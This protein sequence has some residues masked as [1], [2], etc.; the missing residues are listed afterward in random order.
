M[1]QD[2]TPEELAELC[3]VH[4]STVRRWIANGSVTAI[5]LPGGMYRIPGA[6]VERLRQP[7]QIVGA[8]R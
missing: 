6:E 2:F 1:E 3:R 5:R 7:I 8:Q 4:V